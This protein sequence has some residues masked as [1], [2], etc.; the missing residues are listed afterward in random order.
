MILPASLVGDGQIQ[1]FASLE[2]GNTTE[3]SGNTTEV[4]GTTEIILQDMNGTRVLSSEQEGNIC[5]E[6]PEGGCLPDWPG[7]ES[8]LRV[9]IMNITME[10]PTGREIVAFENITVNCSPL[11]NTTGSTRCI[12]E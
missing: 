1:T 6:T 10:D 8:V 5:W 12:Q 7:L 2:S 9:M 11:E 4:A 3:I